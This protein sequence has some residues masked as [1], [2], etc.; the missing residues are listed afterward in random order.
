L[1]DPAEALSGRAGGRGIRALLRSGMQREALATMLA[2]PDGLGRCRLRRV[3]LKPGR[4]LTA[5]YDIS[6]EGAVGTR[7]VAVTWTA[8][9]VAFGDVDE[10]A[11]CDVKAGERGLL[12][13]FRSLHSERP[14]LA[15][16]VA[17]TP[18]DLTCTNL[19]DLCDRTYVSAMLNRVVDQWPRDTSVGIRTIRYR[20]GER[21]V[22]RYTSV[23]D[24]AQVF[25]AKIHRPSIAGDGASLSRTQR[26]AA[27]AAALD[28]RLQ[29]QTQNMRAAAP[30][31]VLGPEGVVL[32]PS[33]P[34]R[35]LLAEL[36]NGAASA[37]P[38]LA[39]AGELLR[40][41]HQDPGV[42]TVAVPRRNHHAE[43]AATR[44]ACEHITGL[45]PH[46]VGGLDQVM[47]RS[48]DLL[49]RLPGE[50]EGFT[51]GD[52]K[53]EHV[54]T[55]SGG[56]TT[57]IDFDSCVQTGLSADLGKFL[58][59][60]RYWFVTWSRPGLDEAQ[61]RFLAGYGLDAGDP[62]L[63]RARLYEAILLVKLAARRVRVDDVDWST[64]VSI[65]VAE[66][67]ALVTR[68]TPRK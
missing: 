36:V 40:T 29:A 67:D 30:A 8:G 50:P 42:Q 68:S 44:R 21:H 12:A 63:N 59:D 20:P 7:S 25:F 1:I 22:L 32:Y 28:G 54:L 4:K 2:A 15:M 9:P 24:T 55:T 27:V 56:R 34:G 6:F 39:T 66:A 41:L 3:K 26:G 57:L 33:V 53:A 31:A 16:R 17:V 5:H 43:I 18:L 52:Y 46:L 19:I 60:L 14:D 11:A 10:F 38:G 62:T 35:S 47:E 49:D 48:A 13:P 51:H 58:A 64:R 45:L 61:R 65:L 37:G 23:A